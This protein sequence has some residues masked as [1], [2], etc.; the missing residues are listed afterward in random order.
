[1]KKLALTLLL[2]GMVLFAV[3]ALAQDKYEPLKVTGSDVSNGVVLLSV[4]IAGA[5][6]DLQCNADV[7]N[8]AKLQPGNYV[9]V[10]LPKNWG[11]YECTNVDLYRPPVSSGLVE[12]KLGDKLG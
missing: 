12:D 3:N 5:R 2:F 9:M 6:F 7:P 8:C 1:M 4:Q 10:R 11:L